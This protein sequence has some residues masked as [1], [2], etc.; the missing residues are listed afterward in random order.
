[1]GVLALFEEIG[2]RGFLV[3]ALARL[4][5][6][7]RVAALSGLAWAAFHFPL[8]LLVPGAAH[9]LPSWYALTTFT[10]MVMLVS[11][12]CAWQ[13]LR[14]GSLWPVMLMHAT[15]NVLVYAIFEPLTTDTGI[16]AYAQGEMGFALAVMV[17]PVALACW[18]PAARAARE[19]AAGYAGQ[20]AAGRP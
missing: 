13:R 15:H 2:W 14:S 5:P 11:V 10:L 17:V 9:G 7:G 16:T 1:M 8:I 19:R 12:P 6:P 18:R 3:P 4:V 20:I